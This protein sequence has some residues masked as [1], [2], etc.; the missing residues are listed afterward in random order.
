[1]IV[2]PDLF[3]AASAPRGDVVPL[4]QFVVN[5]SLHVLFFLLDRQ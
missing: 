1:M 4:P 3:G 2:S 5:T